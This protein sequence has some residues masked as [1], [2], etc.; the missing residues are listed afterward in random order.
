MADVPARYVEVLKAVCDLPTAPFCEEEVAGW[1]MAWASGLG[2]KHRRD[3]AGNLYVEYVKG[4]RSETPG[5]IEAHMDH[6]GFL[7]V[8]EEAGLVRAEFR[9][10]VK[11]SYFPGSLARFWME[12]E[13]RWVEAKVLEVKTRESGRAMDVWLKCKEMVAVGTLGMWDLPDASVDGD[14]FSARV[15]DDLAGCGAMVCTME[16]LLKQQ[17]PGHVILLFSRA[18]EVGF[19][20][21]IAVCE[22]GWIPEGS[23]VIGLEMSKEVGVVRQAKGP[24]VRVGDRTGLFS[25]GLTHFLMQA[26]GHVGDADST[27]NVQ[28][29]LMDGGMCSTTALTAWGY[30]AA[31]MCLPLRGYH[32]MSDTDATIV[33]ESISLSDFSGMVRI[34]VEAIKRIDKYKPGFGEIRDRLAKMHAEEQEE[35]LYGTAG[36]SHRSNPEK[37]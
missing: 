12:R 31:A 13:R 30:D 25:A 21:V 28:R 3:A 4:E 24:V 8:R 34:L 32:N 7:V 35:M 26:A 27:L 16:E 37:L 29:A 20:G 2:L 11:P 33:P 23:R 15:C 10:G 1:L 14:I 36:T 18:E 19:A 5:V 9:G 17:V 22:K 6:P